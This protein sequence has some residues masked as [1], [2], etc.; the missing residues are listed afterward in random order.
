MN[1]VI[2]TQEMVDDAAFWIEQYHKFLRDWINDIA[3]K[4]DALIMNG[5]AGCVHRKMRSD[6]DCE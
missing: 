1:E 3:K 2:V 5:D 4:E 6:D